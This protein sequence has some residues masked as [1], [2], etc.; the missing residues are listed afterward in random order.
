ML[1]K[2]SAERG[3]GNWP[4]L[5]NM[6]IERMGRPEYTPNPELKKIFETISE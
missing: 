6:I 3:L 1:Q 5:Q 4:A 2:F